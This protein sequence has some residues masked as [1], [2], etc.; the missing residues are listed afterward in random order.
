MKTQLTFEDI[1]VNPSV[2]PADEIRL[3]AQG[4]KMYYRLIRCGVL[5]RDVVE[6]LQRCKGQ[7]DNN[8]YALPT[9]EELQRISHSLNPT[10]R[11]FEVR[12]ALQLI[13][14]DLVCIRGKKGTGKNYYCICEG[15]N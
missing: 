9:N 6:N 15:K 12:R 13:G 1:L 14:Q 10:A 7:F 2:A 5:R 8:M 11:H 3:S 4:M